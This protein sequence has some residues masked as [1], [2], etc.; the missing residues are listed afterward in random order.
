MYELVGPGFI[1]SFIL[2]LLTIIGPV[3]LI[4]LIIYILWKRRRK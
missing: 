4:I 1:I 2:A 3:L